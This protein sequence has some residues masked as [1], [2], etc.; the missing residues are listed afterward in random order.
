MRI[1]RNPW[2]LL[3]LFGL[4]VLATRLPLAPGQLFTFDDVNLAYSIGHYDI[5]ISQPQPP[6]YPLF[7]L[8]MRILHW[9]HFKRAESILLVLALL[10]SIVALLAAVYCGNLIFGGDSGFWGALVLWLA[11]TFWHAGITSALRVQLAIVS[12]GVAACCWKAWCGDGAWVTP[13]AIALAIGAGIRPETGVLL[14]PLWAVSA[15][16]AKVGWPRRLRAL[17]WMALTVLTWLLPAM[18]ASGGPLSFIRANLDYISDQA[19]VSSGLFG[20]AGGVWMRTFFRLVA[21]IFAILLGLVLAAVVAWRRGEGW[22]VGRQRWAFLG[23]WLLP[24]FAFALNVHVEDPGQTLI[25]VVVV[26]LFSGFLIERA[27]GRIESQVARYLLL[28]MLVAAWILGRAHLNDTG[29]LL[30]LAL[31]A[32]AAG[33]AFHFAPV[34]NPGVLPR[35]EAALWLLAPV[36]YT[37]AIYFTHHGWYYRGSASGGIAAAAGQAWADLN[38]G[39]ALCSLDQVKDT[40]AVDDHSLRETRRLAAERPGSIVVWEHGLVAWRKVGYYLPGV[41]VFV[42]DHKM[43]RGGNPVA[44][45]WQGA[46]LLARQQGPAP[47]RVTLPAGA[48]VIWLLNPRT[49]FYELVRQSFPLTASGPVYYSE[50]PAAA[51]SRVLREYELAW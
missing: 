6:G 42:L 7:V 27:L 18:L 36:L 29:P 4:L 30:G 48:R 50:L 51:G 31:T 34:R 11:P 45:L 2:L 26:A 47:L 38:S 22:G 43:I 13:G 20:A 46:G 21:W 1:A 23:L 8:E 24:A 14:F 12:L 44:D 25:M 5:R 9:L 32:A 3:T 33:A 16:R 17:L 15:L 39:F 49:E 40:L 19:S 41:K 35:W 37:N 10:G 28:P